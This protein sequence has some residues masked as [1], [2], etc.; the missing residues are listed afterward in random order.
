[1]CQPPVRVFG[2]FVKLLTPCPA[3]GHHPAGNVSPAMAGAASFAE[4]VMEMLF[5]NVPHTDGE[6]P[7]LP[8]AV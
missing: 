1:M 2:S 6:T 5:P 8:G 7:L 3:L 4:S